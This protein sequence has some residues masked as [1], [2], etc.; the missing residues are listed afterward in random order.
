M[1]CREVTML[2]VKEILRLWLLGVRLLDT[3]R[4][5]R[6]Q[7]APHRLHVEASCEAICFFGRPSRP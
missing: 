4:L 1:A 3:T 6:R 7:V 2:E 5:R